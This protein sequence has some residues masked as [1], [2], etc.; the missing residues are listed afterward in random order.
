MTYIP[1]MTMNSVYSDLSLQ[2]CFPF[3][4]LDRHQDQH[5]LVDLSFRFCRYTLYNLLDIAIVLVKSLIASFSLF[6]TFF[7]RLPLVAY[8]ARHNH[9]VN[10]HP[11]HA[12]QP[13]QSW[14]AI[15]V[16]IC[17][18]ISSDIFFINEL[19]I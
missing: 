10:E 3:F 5:S 7:P 14:R 8:Y 16:S 15:T 18:T 12:L 6:G 13:R 19:D 2:N 9:K 4:I 11:V 17:G 1:V